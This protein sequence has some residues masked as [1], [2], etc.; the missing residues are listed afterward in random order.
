MCMWFIKRIIGFLKEEKIEISE[1]FCEMF[2]SFQY[3][4]VNKQTRQ[5]RSGFKV[6]VRGLDSD[7]RKALV[8]G[9]IWAEFAQVRFLPC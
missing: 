3:K 1:F 7:V 4:C 9:D 6:R 5:V 8:K 2:S